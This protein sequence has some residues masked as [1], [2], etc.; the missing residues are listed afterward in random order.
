MFYRR[1]LPHWQPASAEYF[2]TVRLDGSLPK[3]AILKLKQEQKLL[4]QNVQ[5]SS[6]GMDS[7][8]ALRERIHKNIFKKYEQLLDS[9]EVGPTW[10]S[11]PG[12][13]K[14]VKEAI[15]YRDQ[16]E[17]DLYAYCVM[18]NHVHLVFK[19]LSAQVT[20]DKNE[21]PVTE[22]MASLKNTLQDCVM[23]NWVEL[24]TH[25]GKRKVMTM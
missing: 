4:M 10:L 2:I 6:R 15:H 21:Y 18:S 13:A 8:S 5:S 16:K 24:A 14:I 9:S 23:L 1:N 3:Q 7:L 17:Y 11:K 20:Q 25:F 12:I 19:L 22:V